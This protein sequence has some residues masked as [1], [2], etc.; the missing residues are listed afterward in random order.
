MPV[1]TTEHFFFRCHD[2]MTKWESPNDVLK[3][4]PPALL[5]EGGHGED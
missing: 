2:V 1:L 5:G 4:L 3:Q